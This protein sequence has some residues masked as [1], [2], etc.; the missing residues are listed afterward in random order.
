MQI[1][2]QDKTNSDLS[3]GFVPGWYVL[4]CFMRLN[5]TFLVA[6]H[7]QNVC[8]GAFGFIK[9]RLR[10]TNVLCAAD[11]RKVIDNGTSSTVAISGADV[12]WVN[13]KEFLAGVFMTPTDCTISN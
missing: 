2:V 3:Y 13:W 10:R 7:T 6:G 4:V 9:R 5:L 8:D 1:I 12:K 11:M